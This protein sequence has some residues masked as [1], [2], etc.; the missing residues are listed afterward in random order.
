MN[1]VKERLKNAAEFAPNYELLNDAL[2]EIERLERLAG[3]LAE[4]EPAEPTETIQQWA[5]RLGH[6]ALQ[7]LDVRLT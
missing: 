2:A 1:N 5:T 6:Q 3:G 7:G 4:A